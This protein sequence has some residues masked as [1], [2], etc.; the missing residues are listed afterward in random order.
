MTVNIPVHEH[1][2]TT[3]IES[4][5][6]MHSGIEWTQDWMMIPVFPHWKIII[7]L[8]PFRLHESP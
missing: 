6:W 1:A 2:P 3:G 8:V 4:L 7:T 5:L